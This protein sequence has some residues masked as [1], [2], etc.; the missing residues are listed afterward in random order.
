MSTCVRYDGQ[1]HVVTLSVRCLYPSGHTSCHI[2]SSA[3]SFYDCWLEYTKRVQ[4]VLLHLHSS[5]D[6]SHTVP[7]PGDM[8]SPAA[9]RDVSEQRATQQTDHLDLLVCKLIIL[10]CQSAN[11]SIFQS[12]E[13]VVIDCFAYF[14]S[15]CLQTGCFANLGETFKGKF[16][17]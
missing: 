13:G 3:L 9:Y 4:R 7:I 16:A 14:L 17:D 5:C 6:G 2:V 11:S 15:F 10:T 12:C 8:N 1:R